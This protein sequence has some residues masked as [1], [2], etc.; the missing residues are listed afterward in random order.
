[1]MNREIF[2]DGIFGFHAQ[3]AVE[4]AL[5]AWLAVCGQQYPLRHDLGE[6]LD[7]LSRQGCDIERFREL[8][9]Y[10]EFAVRL[11]Y[12]AIDEDSPELDRN[13]VCAEIK[14]VVEHVEKIIQNTQD[15]G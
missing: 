8:I 11:R 7:L 3:Q 4:K 9:K 2:N 5:K 12:E 6:L 10:T 13:A 15:I 14:L 1:M